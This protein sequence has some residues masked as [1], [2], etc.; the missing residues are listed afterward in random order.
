MNNFKFKKN[1]RVVK[2]GPPYTKN[3]GGLGTIVGYGLKDIRE[4]R[5]CYY[6]HFDGNSLKTKSCYHINFLKKISPTSKTELFITENKL[7][8]LLDRIIMARV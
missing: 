4:G 7:R 8:S 3:I 6:V 1:D 2:I 5:E